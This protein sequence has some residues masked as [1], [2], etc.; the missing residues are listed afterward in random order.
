MEGE[1]TASINQQLS[2]MHD[3][4]LPTLDDN[5]KSGNSL[6]DLDFYENELDFE[7]GMEKK[8]KPFN[9]QS[10]FPQVFKQGGFD[11]II[12]NP[13]WVSLNGKFGNDIVS[14]GTLQYLL[15]KYRSNTYMPNLYELFIYRGL[16]L[17]STKGYFSFIVPDRLGFNSQFTNLRTKILNEFK[18]I[19]LLYK[20]P[21][22]GIIT[23]TLI[24]NF[25]F[26]N[27]NNKNYFFEVGEFGKTLQQKSKEIFW[28]NELKAFTYESSD[29]AKI[30]IDKVFL[31]PKCLN[32][33][34]IIDSTSGF[35]GKSTEIYESRQTED[36]IEVLRGRSI[37]RYSVKNN[38]YF[39]FKK[40]NITGR[41]TDIS[42]LGFKEKVLLRKTGYPI[43][44]TFDET[45]KFPEQSLYFLYNVKNELSYKYL[46]AI[47]NS[48]LFQF[49][50]IN[51]LVTNKDSTPQL[52]KT[53]LDRFPVYNFDFNNES[54]KQKHDN[55]VKLVE[56][57]LQL[58]KDLQAA[59]L[60]EQKEQLQAR[61][62]YTD[63]KID[64][65]VYQLYELTEAEINIV[66][67]E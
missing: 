27:D 28:N 65:L 22:P 38:Y 40:S 60:P 3:K 6:I 15:E 10:A 52:K 49:I 62:S 47:I 25:C 8:I 34:L 23:D 46:A 61:I 39:E 12:G 50:Y 21:F 42:K 67:G 64:Q 13:P 17:I 7:P 59:T 37:A 35:G 44:A 36:Q 48:K 1:T 11:A 5:I 26:N 66:E 24:F 43:I 33:S 19:E 2:L 31:N 53:D 32:L 18:I 29:N 58:N 63:K 9:W 56:T 16:D 30:V 14:S 4:V 20:A 57:M 54:D 55:L 51:C 41:T 45:G